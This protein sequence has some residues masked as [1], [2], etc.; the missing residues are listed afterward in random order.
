MSSESSIRDNL[1]DLTLDTTREIGRKITE[2]C[3]I[4]NGGSEILLIFTH[5]IYLLMVPP[6]FEY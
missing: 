4:Q 1:P 2:N 3:S 6:S 5:S